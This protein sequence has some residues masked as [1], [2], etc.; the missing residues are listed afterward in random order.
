MLQLHLAACDRAGEKQHMEGLR[1]LSDFYT[2][3]YLSQQPVSIKKDM[4]WFLFLFFF[5]FLHM[6]SF[7]RV[8]CY[9]T[10]DRNLEHPCQVLAMNWFPFFFFFHRL[11]QR[12]RDFSGLTF[13]VSPTFKLYCP[14]EYPTR[15]VGGIETIKIHLVPRLRRNPWA[16]ILTD[17]CSTWNAIDSN[18]LGSQWTKEW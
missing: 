4:S 7:L 11:G 8:P 12:S 3:N 18:F 16:F 6:Q 15:F 17:F 14:T 1:G 9:L 13:G 5:F 2:P 10:N